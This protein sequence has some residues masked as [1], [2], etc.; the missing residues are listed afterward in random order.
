MAKDI[1][2]ETELYGVD[3]L[4]DKYSDEEKKELLSKWESKYGPIIKYQFFGDMDFLTNFINKIPAEEWD[5][6]ISNT[7]NYKEGY[8]KKDEYN[9]QYVIVARRAVP[10]YESKPEN[11]WTS[12]ADEVFRGL[13]NEVRKEQRLH[14]V[15]MISTLEKLNQHGR[16]YTNRGV[17]D[18][19]IALDPNKTFSDFLFRYKPCREL[20]S[21][22]QYL[23]NG[24]KSREEVLA[25]LR[26]TAVERAIAQGLPVNAEVTRKNNSLYEEESEELTD[27]DNARWISLDNIEDATSNQTLSDIN[28]ETQYLN[29][30]VQRK[31]NEK[32]KGKEQ[33]EDGWE[34]EDDW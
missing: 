2:E 18:G 7:I 29:Q 25:E 30:I 22:Q 14:S 1:W 12:N 11:F 4:E 19:E 23:D 3:E 15:I 24:G 21:L 8:A 26:E 9:P 13:S 33:E 16:V 6:Y 17:S 31:S 27:D 10:S 32:S 28:S 5:K 20:Y 34:Q